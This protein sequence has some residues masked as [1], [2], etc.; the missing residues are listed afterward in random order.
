MS[1]DTAVVGAGVVSDSHLYALRESPLTNAVALCDLDEERAKDKAAEYGVRWYTD[2][3]AMVEA[4]DLD[5]LHV[6]TPVQ[7][8]LDVALAA[9]DAGIPIQIEKPVAQSIEEVERLEDAADDLPISVVHNHNFDRAMR[10]AMSAVNDGEIGAVRSVDL[11]FTGETPPDLVQRGSWTFDLPGGEFEEGIPHP[12]YL[13]LRSG[14]YP[15]STEAIQAITTRSRDYDQG[16]TYDGFRV[17]YTSEEGVLCG[18]VVLSG[19]IPNRVLH[20]H[21]DEGAIMADLVSQTVVNLDRDYL[22]SPAARAHNN[23]DRIRD[24]FVGTIG[25]LQ[26]VAHRRFEESWESEKELSSHY[27]QIDAEARAL[28]EGKPPLVPLAEGKWTI[29]LMEAI[30]ESARAGPASETTGVQIS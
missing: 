28:L 10:A 19:S 4:E 3:D 9:I 17:Q 16:F 21:G 8:H 6:C 5:W 7:S 29:A 12:L 1:I 13:V 2:L 24:R 27:Y 22:S 15:S 20:V 30:R 11:I 23:F 18:T 14:G 25:N 26:A